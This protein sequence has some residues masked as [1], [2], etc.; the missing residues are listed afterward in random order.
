MLLG[1]AL[2]HWSRVAGGD[3]AA[4]YLE[5]GR[6]LTYGELDRLAWRAAAALAERGICGGERVAVLTDNEPEAL[7]LYYGAS[8][9]GAVAVP[10]STRLA[11]PEVANVVEQAA[12][13]GALVGAAHRG[14]IAPLRG[15]LDF[16]WTLGEPD[17]D[18]FESLE[19]VLAAASGEPPVPTDDAPLFEMYTSGTTGR[20][21]GVVTSQRAWVASMWAQAFARDA[22]RELVLLHTLPLGHVGGT[23]WLL[24]PTFV[25]GKVVVAPR[26]RPETVLD[27]AETE[28]LTELVVVPTMLRLLLD[29]PSLAGR[30]LARLRRIYCGG[31]YLDEELA[32]RA[33]AARM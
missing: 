10:I 7:A 16:L 12:P 33:R 19:S 13:R 27:A 3:T 32:A 21:K 30:D 15:R 9:A 26:F 28:G 20:P 6:R 24:F 14:A 2:A 25:G 18:S 22:G 5:T 11:P 17:G 1:D 8:R 4:V 23:N 31:A 29:H